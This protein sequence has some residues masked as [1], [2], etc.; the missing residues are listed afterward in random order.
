MSKQLLRMGIVVVVVLVV[1]S[2]MGGDPVRAQTVPTPTATAVPCQGPQVWANPTG[3][4]SFSAGAQIVASVCIQ[5]ASSTSGQ[6]G[7]GPVL[8]G[9]YT[10]SGVG[11]ASATVTRSNVAAA[12]Q[13]V[14]IYGQYAAAPATPSATATATPAPAGSSV[15]SGAI[16]SGAIP[17]AGGF[18][19]IVFGGGTI[20]QLATATKCPTATMA[21]WATVGGRFVMYVPSA[22]AVNTEFLALF[23]GGNIPA[24]TAFIGKCG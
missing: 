16:A 1:G 4:V 23:P 20:S 9:C 8:N 17:A 24:N 21:L 18:G 5:L 6:V 3:S 14:N 12:C 22:P 13:A 2:V 19:L 10:V 7:N 15:G 11:T